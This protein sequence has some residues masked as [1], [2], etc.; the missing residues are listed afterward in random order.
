M[1]K[2]VLFIDRDGTIIKEA[3]P[4]YQLDAF[5]KLEFYPKVF[6][7]L[8]KIVKEFDYELVMV[9]NQDGLGTEAFPEDSFWPIQ[10]FVLSALEN[11]GIVF[12]EIFIDRTFPHENKPTRKPGTGM[13]EDYLNTEKYDLKNSFVIGDRLTDVQL[14]K[15]L[16]CR[17]FWLNNHDGLGNDEL[18]ITEN[19]FK[20][21][22]ALETQKWEDIYN[23]LKQPP[24][25]ITH[26]RNTN[27]TKIEV[28]V[29]LDGNGIADNKTGLGFFDHML[30]QVAKHSGMDLKIHCEGDLHIDEHHTIEDVA[31]ALGEAVL[32]TLGDK[33]GIE[34]YGYLLPMDDCLAQVAIDFGGRSWLVWD[35]EFK[36]EKIGEMPTEMFYHFFKSFSDASK[37]NLNIKAEGA[38]EHHKI[39]AIFKAFAKAIKMAIRRDPLNNSLPTTKG[40]L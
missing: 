2:K 18:T 16:G 40:L 10:H 24:R 4:T 14:A 13:L 38:N 20:E 32:A 7:Y 15:N 12:S 25:K 3:P 35:V 39:E 36:R 31:L 8:T 26:S 37:S 9:T 21:I 11:E 29:N 30:D 28:A 33:R 34:R 1:S 19:A 5:A 27:E 23:F 6:E 22:I 17:A